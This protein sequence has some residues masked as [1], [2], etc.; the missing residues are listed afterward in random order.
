MFTVTE[1][2]PLFT[3]LQAGYIADVIAV[4]IG[5]CVIEKH[6]TLD[7]SMEG[8]DHK[9]SLD[10]VELKELVQAIRMTEVML[11]NGEKKPAPEEVLVADVIRKSIITRRRIFSG[12]IIKG[13]D[14]IIKRPGN[15][16][17]PKQINEIIGKKAVKDI[18]ED[19]QL[20]REDYE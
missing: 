17:P 19:T 4:A 15:G 5:A 8:P 9:A 7:K 2:L 18:P 20:K 12:A 13:E 16:I 11:G 6:F 1:A 3:P 10:P 14:L